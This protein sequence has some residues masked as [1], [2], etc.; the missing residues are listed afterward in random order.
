VELWVTLT[1]KLKPAIDQEVAASALRALTSWT[2]INTDTE[3][4]LSA[5]ERSRQ[6][7]ISLWDAL[8]VEAARVAGCSS[9]YSEDLQDGGKYG[10]V[11]V[12][13][14]FSVRG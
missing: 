13:N 5:V 2:V 4:V 10:G 8:I 7:G 1:R 6:S 12:V 9:V 14:P 3:L 11:R